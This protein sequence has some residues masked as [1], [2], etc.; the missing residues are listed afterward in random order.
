MGEEVLAALAG[1]RNWLG[2]SGKVRVYSRCRG[3]IQRP[4]R[5]LSVSPRFISEMTEPNTITFRIRIP[6]R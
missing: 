5:R 3:S 4:F 2:V 1:R 6:G